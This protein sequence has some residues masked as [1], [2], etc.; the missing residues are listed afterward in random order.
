MV[1]GRIFEDEVDKMPSVSFREE[2]ED[3]TSANE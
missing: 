1:E 3:H 2:L